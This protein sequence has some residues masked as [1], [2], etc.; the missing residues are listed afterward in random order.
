MLLE[1][2]KR[3]GAVKEVNLISI[4]VQT[5]GG[6]ETKV[7]LDD[8]DNT[9]MSLKQTILDEQGISSFSQ[10]LFLVSKGDE[11][12]NAGA[13]GGAGAKQEPLGDDYLILVDCCVALCIESEVLTAWDCS[14]PLISVSI[15]L[16][17]FILLNLTGTVLCFRTR[18]LLLAGKAAAS[19]P[20]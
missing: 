2:A 7:T 9:V 4:T 5:M 16:C 12:N 15:Y 10:Q 3:Q 19:L 14:S 20:R 13:G 17:A 6:T 18:Y 11:N 1:F 8:S